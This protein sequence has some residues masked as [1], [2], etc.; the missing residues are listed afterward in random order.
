MP[1]RNLWTRE[2]LIVT[3][4]LYFQLPF[5]WLNHG[6]QYHFRCNAPGPDGSVGLMDVYTTLSE[7]DTAFFTL[8][9]R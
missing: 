8:M 9:G 4:A 5:G 3:L 6:T 2:E 1:Q 7:S